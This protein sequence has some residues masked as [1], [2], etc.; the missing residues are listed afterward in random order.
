MYVA[1]AAI[2]MLLSM[3]FVTSAILR[4]QLRTMAG[5]EDS[6]VAL[7]AADT[8]IEEVLVDV[9]H[10][11]VDPQASYGGALGNGAIYDVRV[12]CCG[13][14]PNCVYEQGVLCP[15]HLSKS[16]ACQSVY[17]CVE[18]RGYFG[19]ASETEKTQRA[20]RVAL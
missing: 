10:K 6:V 3:V 1:I 2:T 9:I 13:A 12:V 7:Y 15:S 16:I 19:P 14:G 8:G 18:S 11:R 4:K 17:F 5:L 20:I